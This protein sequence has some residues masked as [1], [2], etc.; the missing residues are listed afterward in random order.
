MNRPTRQGFCVLGSAPI[1]LTLVALVPGVSAQPIPGTNLNLTWSVA[2]NAGTGLF[3]YRYNITNNGA[4]AIV[5]GVRLTAAEDQFRGHA[6]LHD[7]GAF[8]NDGGVFQYDRVLAGFPAHNYDWN[9]LNVPAFGT[10]TVG[11]SDIHGPTMA[12]YRVENGAA[13]LQFNAGLPLGIPVPALQNQGSIGLIVLG[14]PDAG[15]RKEYTMLGSAAVAVAGGWDYLYFLRNTG[16]VAIGP[17]TNPPNDNHADLY[18]NEHPAH[19][20]GRHDEFFPGI[21]PNNNTYATAAGLDLGHGAEPVPANPH[22]YAW[23]GLGDGLGAGAAGWLPGQTLT[24]SFH[25]P[26]HGPGVAGWGGVVVGSEADQSFSSL[27][28]VVPVPVVIPEPASLILMGLAVPGFLTFAWRK[29]KER[30][31]GRKVVRAVL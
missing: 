3:D 7:E 2:F 23:V 15:K 20:P 17:D 10:T 13:L 28:E 27:A 18:V 16:Q 30:G 26:V 22:H 25:D 21:L 24:L 29:E 9:A 6:G 8:L 11:F 1:L 19:P 12:P 31:R 4:A 5:N 14:G